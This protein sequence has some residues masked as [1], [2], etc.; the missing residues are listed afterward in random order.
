MRDTKA[1]DQALADTDGA[2]GYRRV[3]ARQPVG[4]AALHVQHDATPRVTDT[5]R[6]PY[7][8]RPP[9]TRVSIAVAY[10]RLVRLRSAH[11]G[12]W[13]ADLNADGKYPAVGEFAARDVAIEDFSENAVPSAFEISFEDRPDVPRVVFASE[14]AVRQVAVQP[15]L[16]QVSWHRGKSADYPRFEPIHEDFRHKLESWRSFVAAQALGD[17]VPE[18][19]EFAY[20]ND[21]VRGDG[22]DTIGELRDMFKIAVGRDYGGE[23]QEF[24]YADQTLVTAPEWPGSFRIYVSFFAHPNALTEP[25]A[26]LSI[27]VRGLVGSSGSEGQIDD[28]IRIAHDLA[29]DTFVKLLTERAE[30]HW[31]RIRG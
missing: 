3:E 18:L 31:G 13:W 16:L 7:F 10:D 19:V 5:P 14:N 28:P 23:Q 22:W 2:I 27:I 6:L 20:F 8:H 11:A 30:E 24:H 9:V 25:D 17:F 4:K 12:L 21:L 15:D 1:Q 26:S 29:S